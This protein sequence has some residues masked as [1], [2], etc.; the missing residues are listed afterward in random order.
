MGVE[1]SIH[2][3]G[4][5]FLVVEE[6]GP[7]SAVLNVDLPPAGQPEVEVQ[8]V[9]EPLPLE[10]RFT[11]LAQLLEVDRPGGGAGRGLDRSLGHR[12]KELANR[13]GPSG[14]CSS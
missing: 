7:G 2:I 8:D 5:Q 12:Q 14:L 13:D 6:V 1:R 9:L 3:D 4:H 11:A 10:V